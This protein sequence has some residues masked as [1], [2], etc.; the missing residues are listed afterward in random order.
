M[1]LTYK[2][3]KRIGTIAP[4][5]PIIQDRTIIHLGGRIVKRSTVFFFSRSI[6]V[7]KAKINEITSVVGMKISFKFVLWFL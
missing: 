1:P 7:I 3:V 5:A 4:H 6:S 2:L